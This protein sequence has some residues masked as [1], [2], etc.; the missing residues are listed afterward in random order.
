MDSSAQTVLKIWARSFFR[1]ALSATNFGFLQSSSLHPNATSD[2][3]YCNNSPIQNN[4]LRHTTMGK[5]SKNP[6]KSSAAP[7]ASV[8]STAGYPSDGPSQEELSRLPTSSSSLQAKLDQLVSFIESNNRAAF[9]DQF[10]PLD[11]SADDKQAYLDNLTIHRESEGTWRNLA[12]EIAAISIGRGVTE[13][14]GDQI[15]RAVF[16]FE[17]PLLSGCDREVSFVCEDSVNG[18]EWRAEG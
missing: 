14:Q 4:L 18:G 15:H 6:R 2:D 3:S 16:F 9:V 12:A 17:H 11:L 10:V 13:I 7:V 8:E 1:N 5:K